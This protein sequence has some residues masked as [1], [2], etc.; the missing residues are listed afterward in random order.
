MHRWGY[1][2]SVQQFLSE[3]E[4]VV[5]G[6]LTAGSSFDPTISQINAWQST[7]AHLRSQLVGFSGHVFFEFTIPRV[8][9]RA[10]IVLLLEGVI[11][12]LEYKVGSD[13]F[14]TA[15]LDQAQGYAL[16]LKNFHEQS[17]DRLIIPVLISTEAKNLQHKVQFASDG[18]ADPIRSNG[19]N[20]HFII[21]E[22]MALGRGATL[23]PM[24][25]AEG[26][27]KPT[28]TIIEAAQ[29]LY[30]NH[31]VDEI[32][33]NEAG[34]E[35]LSAT[36]EY[37]NKVIESS[38]AEHRKA[39]CFITGVPGSGKTLAGLNIANLRTKIAED[40]HAVFLSGN[41]PLVKV[42]R[43]ALE[44]DA[45]SYHSENN[46]TRSITQFVQNIHHF[47]DDNLDKSTPPIEQVVIFD[48]AQRAWNRD[49]TEKFMKKRSGLD[50]SMSEPEYLISVMDRHPDWCVV[51]CLVGNGQEINTGEAGIAEWLRAITRDYDNWDVHV[52]EYMH[53][54]F[55]ALNISAEP[56]RFKTDPSLHLATSI[57]SFRSER[58]ADYVDLVLNGRPNEAADLF[59]NLDK[60][61]IVLTRNINSAREWLRRKR[62]ATERSGVVAFSS[63]IRLKAEGVFVKNEVEPENW[64]LNGRDD[65]R[66]SDYLEDC[67]TEF[68]VQGLELDW[69]CVCIDANLRIAGCILTPMLFRG[70]KWQQV[71]DEERKKYILNAHRVLLTR[72]RQGM[73]IF[74]PLGSAEDH[75]RD[76][77]WYEDIYQYFKSCG[78]PDLGT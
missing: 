34:A 63:A 42:L 67:V 6:A 3:P 9:S 78:L 55:D 16:D 50:F 60:F 52:S 20:I 53:A 27:Y 38:K 51:I 77:R 30:R 21:S 24:K 66:S 69:T 26:R 71:R 70:T 18:V 7:I 13:K 68:D 17:H 36:A 59:R 45:R 11:F 2:A 40:E 4:N 73:V 19:S 74:I 62:R 56:N 57:R 46:A 1:G 22:V 61:E 33:R 15:D 14:L 43:A 39:I 54:R 58:L 65:I 48:E 23:D 41:G 64:F 25:W 72:A 49:Q 32:T 47:R 5:L 76:P 8:G 37:V 28:P 44:R 31:S 29:A 10:D 35:N 75:T 12:I